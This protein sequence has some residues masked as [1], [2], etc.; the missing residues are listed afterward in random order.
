[1]RP[2]ARRSLFWT[3][4]ALAAAAVVWLRWPTE[5]A[6][7]ME[8]YAAATCLP[9]YHSDKGTWWNHVIPL[10]RGSS[11][12]LQSSGAMN[13]MFELA[14]SDEDHRRQVTSWW[15]YSYPHDARINES[16]QTLWLVV[17]GG[18]G[19]ALTWFDN[20][21]LYE[22]DLTTRTIAREV[23]FHPRHLPPRCTLQ[24]TTA[25]PPQTR[26][27]PSSHSRL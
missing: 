23:D 19:G 13:G 1:M 12:R 5:Q 16:T 2:L 15:G 26:D 4:V 3:T 7:Q 20:A 6:R 22:Y 18:L 8:R 27:V 24:R 11:V 25:E 21:R 9:P 14:F 10:A 17:A